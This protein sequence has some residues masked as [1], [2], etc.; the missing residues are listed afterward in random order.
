MGVVVPDKDL[1]NNARVGV[2]RGRALGDQPLK[3]VAAT[4]QDGV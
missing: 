3:R 2:G 1:R 4:R